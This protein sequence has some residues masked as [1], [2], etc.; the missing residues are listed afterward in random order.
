MALLLKSSSYLLCMANAVTLGSLYLYNTS[1]FEMHSIASGV[2]LFNLLEYLYHRVVLHFTT[3]GIIYHY[4]HGNHH[5]KPNGRSLHTPMLFVFILNAIYYFSMRLYFNVNTSSNVGT[6]ITIGYIIFENIHKEAHH[7]YFLSDKN[8]IRN[9][10][11][12]HHTG[13]KFKAFSFS[14]PTWDIIFGTF[15]YEFA[16]YNII[17]LVPIPFVSFLGVHKNI[18]NN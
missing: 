16:T 2:V 11:M 10:H 17:A 6:G 12:H 7:P 3:Q 9:Y 1:R 4:L 13:S 8:I 14:V 18:N 5:I 15:P